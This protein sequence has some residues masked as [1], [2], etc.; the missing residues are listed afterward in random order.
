M[1]EEFNLI[2]VNSQQVL[3]V[4]TSTC[5]VKGYTTSGRDLAGPNTDVV[6]TFTSEHVA[7]ESGKEKHAGKFKKKS[8]R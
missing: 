7:V 3:D 5:M 2:V 6:V 8:G 1:F 4:D